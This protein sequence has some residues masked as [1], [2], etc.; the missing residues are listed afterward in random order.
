MA[1]MTIKRCTP[2]SVGISS[3]AVLQFVEETEKNIKD[4]HSFMLLRHGQAAAEGWWAPYAADRP[5]MLFSLSKSFTSSAIGMAIAEGKLSI[6]DPVVSF[7]PDLLPEVSENL[8]GMRIRQLLSM[9]TGHND[10]ST[11]RMTEQPEG[12]WVKGFLGLAVEHKPGTH[13]VYN[14]GASHMLSAII[15][16]VTGKTLL[17]YLR[18]RLFEP[19]GIANPT[20]ETD[21]RGINT[22]GWGLKICTEDIARFGQMYLQK[23]VWADRRLLSESWVEEASSRQASNGC[24]PESDWDQGYGYQFWRCRHNAYRGDGAFGQFCIVM[25]DQDAVMAITSGVGDMQAVMNL[26]WDLLLT[27]MQ[28]DPLPE[29]AEAVEALRARLAKL[30]YLPP[31]GEDSSP[32]VAQINGRA[33]E[34]EKN[35]MNIER[36]SFEFGSRRCVSTVQVAGENHVLNFGA[37][38]WL[39]GSTDLM[40]RGVQPIAASYAWTDEHTCLMTLRYFET[41]FVQTITCNFDGD[42]LRQVL[43]IN[44]GFGDTGPA[45][46]KGKLAQS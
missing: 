7:F 12:D 24:Y 16:K 15:Q 35:D 31:A 33:Y 41:P 11:G 25:P 21:P 20:W 44:V 18:P 22:G 30:A 5:H 34:I 32:L 29:D 38:E 27:K 26:V 2:E 40:Q 17:E 28:P 6:N 10:D 3:K 46:F 37:G 8:K 36:I 19:L 42:E 14:S 43:Q 39:E 23:G 1:G 4:L 9:S 13:F 45:E